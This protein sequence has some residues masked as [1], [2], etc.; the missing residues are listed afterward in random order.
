MGTG[1]ARVA[2]LYMTWTDANRGEHAGG[3]V[4][5]LAGSWADGVMWEYPVM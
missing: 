1:G 3:N 5:A 4:S 2:L